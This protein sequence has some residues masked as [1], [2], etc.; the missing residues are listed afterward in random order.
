MTST[1][2]SGWTRGGNDDICNATG[3]LK[4]AVQPQASR[5]LLSLSNISRWGMLDGGST[6]EEP[7]P[8]NF[9]LYLGTTPVNAIYLGTQNITDVILG[10]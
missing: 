1:G 8:G 6:P 7:T 2:D 10:G 9:K 5:T 3:M 4:V